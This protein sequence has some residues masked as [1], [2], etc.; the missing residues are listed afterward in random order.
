MEVGPSN[1]TMEK[2]H[3]PWSD[4]KVHGVNRPL[5]YTQQ[6]VVCNCLAPV[7]MVVPR[8]AT[9]LGPLHT[10]AKSHDREIVRAQ[11]KVSKGRPNTPPKLCNVVIDLKCSVKPYVTMP[12]TKCYFNEFLFM[13]VLTHDKIE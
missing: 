11:K 6:F 10:W 4:F 12:L 7:H 8:E 3:V 5:V 9:Q 2:G 1:W 13:Q